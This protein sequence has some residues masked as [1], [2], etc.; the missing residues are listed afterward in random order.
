MGCTSGP[1][2]SGLAIAQLAAGWQ[3]LSGGGNGPSEV[4]CAFLPDFLVAILF[5]AAFFATIGFD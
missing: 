1:G 4:F 3:L 2:E 5:D